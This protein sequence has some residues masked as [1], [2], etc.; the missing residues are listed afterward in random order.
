MLTFARLF[1]FAI[2]APTLALLWFNA[3]REGWTNLYYLLPDLVVCAGLM[4]AAVHGG[5]SLLLVAYAAAGGVFMTATLGGYWTEGLAG[6]PP[7]AAIGAAACGIMIAIILTHQRRQER[8]GGL[9]SAR[10]PG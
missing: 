1:V 2:I 3:Q 9:S 8:V 7:G 4:L 5:S 6:T 10:A